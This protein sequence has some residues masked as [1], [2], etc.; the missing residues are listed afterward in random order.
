MN[1]VYYDTG[2]NAQE[3]HNQIG[4]IIRCPC[5][6]MKDSIYQM[7]QTGIYKELE[8]TPDHLHPNDKGH[9]LVA[10]K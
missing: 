6:S 5:I 8:L 3:F 2:T 10:R 1:N 9:G 4:H 7:I